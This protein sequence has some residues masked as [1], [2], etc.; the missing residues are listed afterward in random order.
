[1][2]AIII[3][4]VRVQLPWKS[5]EISVGKW[6]QLNW[7]YKPIEFQSKECDECT[8]SVFEAIEIEIKSKS[9]AN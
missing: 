6:Q 3:Y 9:N 2:L 7:V 4:T 5:I 1:M 8:G